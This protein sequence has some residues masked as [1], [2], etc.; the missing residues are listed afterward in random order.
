LRPVLGIWNEEIDALYPGQSNQIVMQDGGEQYTCGHLC[1]IIHCEGA[2]PLATYGTDFYAGTPAVTQHSYADGSAYYIASEPEPRFLEDFYARL[3]AEH[4]IQPVL[5]TP[6]GVE[7][8]LRHTAHGK[9]LFLLNHNATPAQIALPAYRRYRDLL[10][11][12]SVTHS[13]TLEGHD[14]AV[15]EEEKV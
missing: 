4:H 1:A 13:I 7:A 15:L 11:D 8:T 14:V 3:V 5:V 10:H 2:T 6:T 9:V 12:D